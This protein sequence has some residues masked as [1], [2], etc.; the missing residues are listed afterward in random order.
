MGISL[1]LFFFVVVDDMFDFGQINGE[2]KG[3]NTIR[4]KHSASQWKQINMAAWKQME[5]REK[6]SLHTIIITTSHRFEIKVF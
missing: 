1:N 2:T 3:E 5:E 6:C 4:I